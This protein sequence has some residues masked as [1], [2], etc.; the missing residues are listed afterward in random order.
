M[1]CFRYRQLERREM[2]S[3]FAGEL[4]LAN[5]ASAKLLKRARQPQFPSS[6][7]IIASSITK[8]YYSQFDREGKH[9]L[10]QAR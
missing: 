1:A 7:E 10:Q 9:R 5:D 4:L 8:R 3:V 6:T 2:H